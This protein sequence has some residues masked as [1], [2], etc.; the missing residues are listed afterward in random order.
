[1]ARS[2]DKAKAGLNVMEVN[3]AVSMMVILLPDEDIAAVYKNNVEPNIKRV[4]SG[5]SARL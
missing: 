4:L 2:W 5:N 1:V 3:D